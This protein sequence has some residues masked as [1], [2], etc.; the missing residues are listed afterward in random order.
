MLQDP[1]VLN[2]WHV[3]GRA[4]EIRVGD[5]RAARLLGTDLVIWRNAEGIHVW[6]DLCRHRGAR[7]SLGTVQNACL[8]CPYH[9]WNYD[10]SG[11]CI[12]IP[13]HPEATR[14]RGARARVFSSQVAYDLIWV[15]LGD[16]AGA[17]P[18]FPAWNDSRYRKVLAGPYPFAAYATRVLEDFLDAGHYPFVHA[19]QL[20]G[21]RNFRMQAYEV[22][23][24]DSGLVSDEIRVRRIWREGPDGTGEV[25]VVYSYQVLRPLTAQYT[26]SYGAECFSMLD[27]VTPVDEGRSLVWSVMAYNYVTGKSDQDLVDYQAKLAAEDA[28]VVE[29]QRPPLLPLDLGQELPV[30]SDRLAVA[31]RQWLKKLGLRFGTS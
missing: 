11:A 14:E 4:P 27:T 6:L 15:C 17:V 25:D 28:I 10:S 2:D 9:G 7:L 29:S 23:A 1:V 21:S 31:Y 19:S 3:V 22:T 20:G 13:A 16:P 8:V 5:V 24:T 12:L 18:A 30:A 26:K